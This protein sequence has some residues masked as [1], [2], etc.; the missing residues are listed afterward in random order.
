MEEMICLYLYDDIVPPAAGTLKTK[1]DV[2]ALARTT[3]QDV[4]IDKNWF[5]TKGGGR[6]MHVARFGVVRNFLAKKDHVYRASLPVPPK[7]QLT[8]YNTNGIF[9][10]YNVSCGE[11]RNFGLKQYEYNLNGNDFVDRCEVFGSSKFEINTGA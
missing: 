6:F 10:A 4:E 5:M 2:L 8:V 1:K 3:R 11:R 9:N 7:G